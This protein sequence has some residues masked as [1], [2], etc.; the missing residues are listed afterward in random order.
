MELLTMNEVSK[1]FKVENSTVRT[2]LNRNKIPPSVIFRLPDTK[3][4]TVR[5][6]KSELEDWISGRLQA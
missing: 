1:I 2:W 6:I 5:F 4:G 3:K